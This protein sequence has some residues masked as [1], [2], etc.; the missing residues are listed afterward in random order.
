MRTLCLMLWMA[1]LLLAVGGQEDARALPAPDAQPAA[2]SSAQPPGSEVPALRFRRLTLTDGLSQ[3]HIYDI[4]QDRRGFMWFATESGLNRYDGH[5]ITVYDPDPFGTNSLSDGTINA[6]HED[7]AGFIWVATQFGGVNRLNPRTDAVAHYQHDPDVSHSL[8]EGPVNAVYKD[9]RG[10]LWV[11]LD[12]GLARMRPG[13]PGHFT[14]YTHRPADSTSLGNN[15]VRSI[16]E[17]AQ[18]RLWIATANGLHRMDLDRPGR[19]QRFLHTPEVAAS[20]VAPGTYALHHQYA[21]DTAPHIRWIGS[22]GGLI[23]FNTQRGTVERVFPFASDTAPRSAVINVSPDPS[24]PGALWVATRNTGLVHLRP[25][26]GAFV[27]YESAPNDRHGLLDLASSLVYTGRSGVVWVGTAGTGVNAFYPRTRAIQHYRSGAQGVLRTP[28]VWGLGTTQDGTLWASTSA[29]YLHRIDPETGAARVWQ[30]PPADAPLRPDAPAGT[31]YDFAESANGTLWIGTGRSLDRYDPATGRFRHYQHVPGDTT[32]LSSHN[33]NVLHTDRDST[34][35]VGT[36]DGLNRY[37]ARTDRFRR[38]THSDSAGRDWIG[39][40]LHDQQGRLWV[41]TEQG[42]C[43]FD[44]ARERFVRHFHHDSTDPATLTKGRFGWIHERPR[45]PGVLWLSSLD[46]GGLDRLDTETGTVTHYTTRTAGLPDNTIYAI[47]P[48]SDGTLWLSTNH[49]LVHFSPDATP[50]DRLVRHVGLESGLQSLEFNQH[51]AAHRNGQ[52]YLG[53]VNG[54]NAFRQGALRGNN[55]PPHT[56]LTALR[57]QNE[58]VAPGPNAPLQRPLSETEQ[59]TLAYDQNQITIA[60][61]GLHFK[62]PARNRYR[63]QLAGYDADWV[64]AGPRREATYTNLAPG[65]YTFRVH[66]A[67]ADGTWSAEPATLQVRITPPWWHTGWAYAAYILLIGGC[68]GGVFA[69]QQRRSRQLE[70]AVD[71]RTRQVRTQ[72]EK[73]AEQARRLKEMNAA[74]RRFFANVSHEFR[75]PLTLLLGPTRD[76]L[77]QQSDLPAAQVDLVY[78]NGKRLQMLINQLLDL[79]ALDDNRLQATPAWYAMQDLV[80]ATVSLF[81][82]LAA[83]KSITLATHL[84]EPPLYVY[85]DAAHLQTVLQNLLS[86][87]VKYTPSGGR[88]DVTLRHAPAAPARAASDACRACVAVADTGPGIPEEEQRHLFERFQRGAGATT[89]AQEGS[90]I[91]LSL[92]QELMHAIEGTLQVDSAPGAGTTFTAR[93]PARMALPEGAVSAPVLDPPSGDAMPDAHAVR[94]ASETAGPEA[95]EAAAADRPVVLVVDDSA[96]V[97]R[98]VR[99]VLEAGGPDAPGVAVMEA[100]NGAQGLEAARTHL[101]DCIVADVMMPE[102][103]GFAMGRALMQDAMTAGIPLLYL[104]ARAHPNDRV[105]GLHLGADAYLA[106]PFERRVLRARVHGLMQKRMR[107]RTLYQQ[108]KEGAAPRTPPAP[109]EEAPGEDAFIETVVGVVR[110]RMSTPDFGVSELAEALHISRSHLYRRLREETDITPSK[111]IRRERLRRARTLLAE[112]EGNV[113]EI[114]YAVGFNS[115]SHFSTSFRKRY[116]ESPSA[117]MDQAAA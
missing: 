114:A 73:L 53:G 84:A 38:Y 46:G 3:G 11:G 75:T 115:L 16:Q 6:L 78:R 102:M 27:R 20:D 39:Y 105:D 95:D 87:A 97:R 110:A 13:R 100:A 116:G 65:T 50:P 15:R 41:A 30:A 117:V 35:W 48:G 104:T 24:A 7:D 51:A 93:M 44:R 83:R 86:N 9:R 37:D 23:R 71:A 68:V 56:V 52:L 80:R 90:G 63:Y 31:A 112:R 76:A 57:I 109:A 19:F 45:E 2:A 28:N 74:K 49:G 17:D 29:G 58:P 89:R 55:T 60:F 66:A 12:N 107:L 33:I 32:S 8:P 103:D 98:Y 91:G 14:H 26:S 47:L 64:D 101:P 96:D 82:P 99:A 10:T 1:G 21:S 36:V 85:A 72:N 113:T 69:M 88:V 34:L 70:A 59:V 4:L 108:T 92:A 22:E 43:Q 81:R 67:N 61:L 106:K 5:R 25:E 18:G 54:I 62:N 94:P 40:V 79:S 42:V 111:L 77:Q